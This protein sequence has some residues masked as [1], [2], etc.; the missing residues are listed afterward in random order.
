[1]KT[2]L[3]PLS[4]ACALLPLYTPAES[5]GQ[6]SGQ[7]LTWTI[8]GDTR[9]A[10]VHAPAPRIGARFP[11]VF[12]FHGRGDNAQNF[13]HTALHLAWPDAIVVYFQ[14]LD[15]R[16]P[17]GLSGWQV[18]RG[19]NSD[20]DLKLVDAALASLRSKY[21]IDDDRVY[22]TGFSNGAMF[23]YLLW[24]ER[25]GV[26]AAYAPNAGRLR[27]SVRPTL[28]RPLFHIAGQR[29]QQVAFSD[30]KAAITIAISV[31][32]VVDRA[33]P[34]GEGCTLY[35]SGTPA[36]VMTWIHSGGHEYPRGTSERIASFFRNHSRT[37]HPAPR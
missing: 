15:T 6:D 30:Q 25:P 2:L 27:P 3:I 26:F 11:L 12:S 16:S 31:N 35:G 36:P 33:T 13:Q 8:D 4:L 10:I 19:E 24:A 37:R 1:L 23:T 17:G 28:P 21:V 20:R 22:A 32:G 7:E 9:K 18:E 14:G 34:C 29:D 5:S